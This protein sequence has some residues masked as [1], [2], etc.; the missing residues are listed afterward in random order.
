MLY[1]KFSI[2]QV[3]SIKMAAD[4]GVFFGNF[5]SLNCSWSINRQKKRRRK[6]LGHVQP[7][8]FMETEKINATRV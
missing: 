2:E 3:C 1:N 7:Y 4:T 5:L 6:E 8:S